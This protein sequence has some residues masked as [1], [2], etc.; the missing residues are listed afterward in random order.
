MADF[1]CA[2]A[3]QGGLET[4]TLATVFDV[5]GR[6]PEFFG[7]FAK[8]NDLSIRHLEKCVG[9]FE[10]VRAGW[11]DI[12]AD[13]NPDWAAPDHQIYDLKV[14]SPGNGGSF[15]FRYS[16]RNP[17]K[18]KQNRSRWEGHAFATADAVW[19]IGVE[20]RE[21]LDAVLF[22]LQEHEEFGFDVLIGVQLAK[23]D[24]GETL[25]GHTRELGVSRRVA[26]FRQHCRRHPPITL[27]NAAQSWV[28]QKPL[29]AVTP[30]RTRRNPTARSG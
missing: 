13:R 26:A 10:I 18:E 17:R 4:Q 21:G 20:P 9:E 23:L 19:L 30:F 11:V 25:P 24:D 27:K 28:E 1:F 6:V 22:V 3:E 16:D 5:R 8:Q 15:V 12:E 29:G 14:W 2:P 7:R